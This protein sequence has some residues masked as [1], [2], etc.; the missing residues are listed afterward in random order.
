[1]SLDGVQDPALVEEGANRASHMAHAMASQ[2]CTGLAPAISRRMAATD[3]PPISKIMSH[4]AASGRDVLTLA[5]G[6][7][8]PVT[9][10][11]G[12]H[13]LELSN[14]SGYV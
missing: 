8:P 6:V 5:Q 10:G 2:S 13:C 9:G 14:A 4:I 12:T 3:H 7:H 1:M 11:P